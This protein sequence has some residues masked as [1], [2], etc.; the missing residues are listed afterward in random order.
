MYRISQSGVVIGYAET[1]FYC[2]RD[3]VS[4][5]IVQCAEDDRDVYGVI[6]GGN[7]YPI[8]GESAAFVQKIDAGDEL[9]KIAPIQQE[10][11]EA[12][13][14]I[15]DLDISNIEAEQAIT[16]LELEILGG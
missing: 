10:L 13:Q 14:I 15:T 9:N 8:S 2:K 4:G 5:T 12:Q 7:I 11:I 6:Y 16:D 3:K 1:V